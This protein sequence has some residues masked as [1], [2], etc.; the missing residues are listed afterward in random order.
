MSLQ[1]LHRKVPQ[2]CVQISRKLLSCYSF[3]K[4]TT[5]CYT[6][7]LRG[8]DSKNLSDASPGPRFHPYSTGNYVRYDTADTVHV[9]ITHERSFVR[10]LGLFD[11]LCSSSACDFGTL[12]FT[13]WVCRKKEE[14][15]LLFFCHMFGNFGR[16]KFAN[17]LNSNE[18]L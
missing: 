18:K 12:H 1:L 14:N 4:S 6:Q 13:K 17:S 9:V 15:I 3:K 5:Y 10:G 7:F 16:K 11:M 8:N 2:P